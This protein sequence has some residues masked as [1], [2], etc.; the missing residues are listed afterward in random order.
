MP[1]SR[2]LGSCFQQLL[3]PILQLTRARKFLVNRLPISRL[4]VGSNRKSGI[5]SDVLDAWECLERQLS[6]TRGWGEC[7]WT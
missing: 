5:S 2:V 4:A 3:I 6:R 7:S 1:S